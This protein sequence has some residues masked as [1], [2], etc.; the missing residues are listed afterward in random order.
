M[1]FIFLFHWYGRSLGTPDFHRK[2][3]VL[4]TRLPFAGDPVMPRPDPNVTRPHPVG[5]PATAPGGDPVILR[6]SLDETRFLLL[7]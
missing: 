2:L 6:A 1:R 5:D 4:A 7:L 3:F